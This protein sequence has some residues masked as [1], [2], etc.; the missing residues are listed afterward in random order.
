[1]KRKLIKETLFLLLS[2]FS[3]L[4]ISSTISE[5]AIY[6]TRSDNLNNAGEPIPDYDMGSYICVFNDD[7]IHPIEFNINLTGALPKNN[8]YLSLF[9]LDVDW[10][11]EVD[12][13][14]LNGHLL[15]YAIGQNNLNY[16][17]FFVIPDISWIK[18]G[19]NTIK[20]LVDRNSS[21]SWCADVVS[22]QL[23]IDEGSGSGPAAI[24]T[25]TL[26]RTTYNFGSN[27]TVNLEVDTTLT[28]QRVRIEMILK[29]PTG[30]NIDFDTNMAGKDWVISSNRDEP[31]S[32]QF[33]IPSTGKEGIWTIYIA[34]YDVSTGVF[35]SFKSLSFQIG[36]GNP[37]PTLTSITPN[38]GQLGQATS[39]T[40]KGFNFVANMTSCSLGGLPISNILVIDGNTITGNVSP[41]LP[42]ATHNL[43][44]TTPYGSAEL[45]NAFSVVFNEPQ[46]T[47]SPASH[48]YGEI[49]I[50][51]SSSKVFT[52][53]N[54]GGKNVNIYDVGV[55]GVITPSANNNTTRDNPILNDRNELIYANHLVDSKVSYI[56]TISQS[57]STTA[58]TREFIKTFDNCIGMTLLIGQSCNFTIEFSP[59]S[60]GIKKGEVSIFYNH[61]SRP[62]YAVSLNGSSPVVNTYA[63]VANS[64]EDTLSVVDFINGAEVTKI[65]T[66]S[67][68]MA[69]AVVSSLNKVYVS[70][71]LSNTVTVIS[72]NTANIKTIAVGANPLGLAVNPTGSKVYVANYGDNTICEIDTVTDMVTRYYDLRNYAYGVVGLVVSPDGGT[73][74]ATSYSNSIVIAINLNTEEKSFVITGKGP[75]GIALH[76]NGSVLY[77][78]NY[79]DG[80]ISVISVSGINMS[81]DGNI[82]IGRTPISLAPTSLGD[83]VYVSDYSSNSLKGFHTNSLIPFEI[84]DPNIVRS[85]G[86][87]IDDKT[88]NVVL[89]L[90]GVNKLYNASKALPVNVGNSPTSFGNNFLGFINI[91]SSPLNVNGN[92]FRQ[93]DVINLTPIYNYNNLLIPP[94]EE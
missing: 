77:T 6:I 24:R 36:Q 88:G 45:K 26:D 69:V 37:P 73:L 47:V 79:A 85:F 94:H 56:S 2:I 71:Y 52:I 75:Y 21:G 39:V 44:C 8:A 84:S 51:Q 91:V 82:F 25:A 86:V 78:S 3:M 46:I 81:Y 90:R 1:M 74:Y 87:A 17:S 34:I 18:E 89:T 54:T 65:N 53:T 66:G 29:D 22:G 4:L 42:I 68:P 31:Y 58:P 14:Y 67:K 61:S 33:K 5:S 35:Q 16:S 43:I 62:Y 59:K 92:Q 38:Q 20:V 10:P 23:I 48:D 70:N 49:K 50:G 13:I 55:Y 11:Y 40:I 32:W 12:E 80:S 72:D 15:G 57:A 64:G 60:G 83:K 19:N 7:P 93:N 27:G 63:F 30:N 28:S 9:I 76:P 41:Q